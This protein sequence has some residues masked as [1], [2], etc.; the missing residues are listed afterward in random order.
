[1]NY[2]PIGGTGTAPNCQW[3]RKLCVTCSSENGETYMRIQSNGLPDH[4]VPG[5]QPMVEKMIDIKFK[6]D[7]SPKTFF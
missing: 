5:K 3:K 4:C 6:Y 7:S 1:M 2:C